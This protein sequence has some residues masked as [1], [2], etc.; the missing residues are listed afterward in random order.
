MESNIK[1]GD[2]KSYETKITNSHTANAF[3]SGGLDVLAT[4][5]LVALIE[6]SAYLLIKDFGFESVGTMINLNH[7]KATLVGDFV[8]SIAKITKI[9]GRSEARRRGKEW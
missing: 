3:G 2:Y 1:V 7:I 8:K 6:A 5:Q 4:P 9:D